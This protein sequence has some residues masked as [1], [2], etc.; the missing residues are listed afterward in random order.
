MGPSRE[1]EEADGPVLFCLPADFPDSKTKSPA[2]FRKELVHICSIPTFVAAT[3][4]TS[5]L[6][7]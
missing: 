6:I 2:S 3:R 7:T 5:S 4:G 1:L